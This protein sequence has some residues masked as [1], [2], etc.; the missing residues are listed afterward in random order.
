MLRT[1][2]Q[3]VVIASCKSSIVYKQGRKIKKEL[4]VPVIVT[5]AKNKPLLLYDG[6]SYT[7]HR[8]LD[9]KVTWICRK[10]NVCHVRLHTDNS[11]G[12]LKFIHEHQHPRDYGEEE[13]LHARS[14]L[15][16]LTETHLPTAEIV[17]ST[18]EKLS[19]AASA[20]LPCLDSLRRTVRR[21]RRIQ[22]QQ[23]EQEEQVQITVDTIK[24]EPQSP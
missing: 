7:V 19:E 15:R 4:N 10:R 8:R 14:N 1:A 24:V 11:G 20:A 13:A 12:I 9:S 18:V 22:Q 23:R 3:Q 2:S 17:K 21:R 16:L 5:S 6:Y